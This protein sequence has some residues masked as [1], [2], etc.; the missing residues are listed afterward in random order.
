MK[1]LIFLA[2]N[3]IVDIHTGI[4]DKQVKIFGVILRCCFHVGSF[5]TILY[6]LSL[7]AMR[8]LYWYWIIKDKRLSSHFVYDWQKLMWNKSNKMSSI[9]THLLCADAS[10][11]GFSLS[12][13]SFF[14]F[15]SFYI[16]M[17]TALIH[18][19]FLVHLTY[20]ILAY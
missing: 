19:L 1:V 10:C 6:L 15:F 8:N 11:F 2:D 9:V 13:F 16:W 14:F 12:F 5:L 18:V 4:T 7:L 17:N 20:K 3:L